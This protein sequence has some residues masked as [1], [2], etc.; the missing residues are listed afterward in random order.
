MQW[1]MIYFVSLSLSPLLPFVSPIRTFFKYLLS[2]IYVFHSSK[3]RTTKH[4]SGA[5][6]R[7]LN[8][9]VIHILSYY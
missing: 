2:P 5:A 4:T 3:L 6:L 1:R 8:I 9:F 7:Y